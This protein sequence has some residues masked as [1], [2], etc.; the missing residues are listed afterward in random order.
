M[1]LTLCLVTRN[2]ALYTTTL[3][4]AM[5]LNMICMIKG[6]SLNIQFVTDQVVPSTKILKGCDRLLWLDYGVSVNQ[7]TLEK[8]ISFDGN[9]VVPCVTGEVDWEK[10][11]K[12]TIENSEEPIHQ[13]GLNFDIEMVP[14]SKR[15]DVSEYVSGSCRVF[16]IDSKQVL[17]KIRESPHEDFKSFDQLKKLGLKIY[18][19]RSAPVTC[20]YVYECIGNILESSGVRATR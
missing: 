19:L 16:A 14:I 5:A 4:S 11:R 17:K 12:K 15:K 3:H 7:D 18:V 2:K 13:R 6:I 10:F 20:H 1:Q 9:I 8:L